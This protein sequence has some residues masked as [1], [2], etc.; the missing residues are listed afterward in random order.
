MKTKEVSA[1]MAALN[2]GNEPK[3]LFVGDTG[4]HEKLPTQTLWIMRA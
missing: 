4:I 1:I 2:D 3:A